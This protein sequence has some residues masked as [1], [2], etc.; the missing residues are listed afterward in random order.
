MRRILGA[1]AQLA[2]ANI[3]ARGIGILSMPLLTLWLSPEAYGQA[4]LASTLISLIAVL[5]LMGMDMSYSRNFLS[6]TN[7]NGVSVETFCWRFTLM[8][9]VISGGVAGTV[10]V[11]STWRDPEVMRVLGWWI[12]TG[13]AMSLLMSM[14][15]TRC[16]L[17]GNFT[18][19]SLATAAGG[20]VATGL[21][22]VLARGATPDE[23]ALVSG[24]VAAYL[25]PVVIMGVPGWRQLL[26]P[27]GLDRENRWFVFKTG[28]PGVMT[29]PMYWVLASSDRWLLQTHLDAAT[30]GLYAIACTFGQL[31][32]MANSALLSIWL[33]EATRL[34]ESI[35]DN[36]NDLM[37]KIMVRL[38]LLML[39]VLLGIGILGGDLLRWLTAEKFHSAARIVPL[40][41]TG[42]FFYGCY[43][44]ARSG[45]YLTRSLKWSAYLSIVVGALSVAVNVSLIPILGMDAAAVVQC[46]S[47]GLLA[48]ST[49]IVAQRKYPLPLPF[50]RIT[51][52]IVVVGICLFLGLQLPTIDGFAVFVL[53]LAFILTSYVVIVL[54]MDPDA[55]RSAQTLYPSIRERLAAKNHGD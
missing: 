30:V 9:A 43:H 49:L 12:F 27:S 18:R 6:R 8:A 46:V 1:S 24:Y 45:L 13:T 54:V 37:A 2:L 51:C 3:F 35:V 44:L 34:H 33:P 28:A 25:V 21:T 40:L 38:V 29:A 5:G 22:L 48:V 31:G 11:V 17:Q 36:R 55:I 26:S 52:G 15:Q 53:K 41:A 19:V 20:I 14:G 42:V 7:P 10:W 32:L 50:G 47:F 16:R 39:A 23:R 4:A